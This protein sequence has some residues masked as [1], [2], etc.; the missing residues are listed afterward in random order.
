[1][2]WSW[3][4]PVGP[5]NGTREIDLIGATGLNL[6]TA[7]RI[8]TT[9]DHDAVLVQHDLPAPVTPAPPKEPDMAL[10]DKVIATAKKEIGTQE[11][12]SN[13]HWNNNQKYSP[14]VPGL[15][16]SQNQAWCATFVSW[17]ALK[18][19]AGDLYPRT[20]SCDVGGSWFKKAGRWSEYPAIGAQVFFGVPSDLS[21]TGIV[22]DYDADSITT[23]EGNTNN[24]GSREGDGVYLM[25]HQR[26]SSRIIGYGYPKFP[27][28]IV[29]AD[30]AWA[31]AAPAPVTPAP[32][33]DDAG[34]NHP[35]DYYRALEATRLKY[36][37]RIDKGR[38]AARAWASTVKAAIAAGK[39]FA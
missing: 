14:A 25:H 17:V 2:P 12:R 32:K 1:M 11:G 3:S 29:S 8:P 21:H 5:T 10:V 39:R 7:R 9:S 35:G 20:A 37:G 24:T 27:E 16:W 15:E 13:G 19:G 4:T 18:S 36:E 38:F 23:V 30:P 28:G 26:R 33:P 22:I 34:P 6:A 31:K